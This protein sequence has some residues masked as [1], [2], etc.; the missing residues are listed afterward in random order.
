MKEFFSKT[1]QKIKIETDSFFPKLIS[2]EWVSK[3]IGE[4]D[5]KFD[6]AAWENAIAGPFHE[7]F[8]RGGKRIRPAMTC[9]A[10]RALGGTSTE[11]YKFAIIPELIH[12]GTL[13]ADDIEDKSD[14]RRGKPVV[15]RIFG[16]PIAINASNFVYFF[17]QLIVTRSEISDE[18][19][20]KIL[21][22]LA[23]DL[24]KLHIGQGMDIY[25]SENKKYDVSVDEYLQMCAYKTGALLGF[26]MKLG[27][28]LTNADKQM[29][30]RLEKI[31]NSLG[32]VFQIRDDILNLKPTTDWGKENGED[33]SEGKFTYMVA[34]AIS[35]ANDADKAELVKIL[36]EK[37][38]DKEKIKKAITILDKYDS[39]K[40][41]NEFS[42]NLLEETKKTLEELFD[43]SEYKTV[44]LEL[45]DYLMDRKY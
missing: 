8:S 44:F 7:L 45:V 34:D 18:L 37:T 38:T 30:D 20:S 5:F 15:N 11:I 19:K 36:S 26:S 1:A 27:A 2:A 35:K 42:H 29:L 41:A 33:I 43:D 28:I 39:F 3:N 17:S 31:G 14:L 24:T 6:F 13:I 23:E 32:I 21:S 10:N 4:V 22:S 40:S 25:W 16:T 12:N 9:L